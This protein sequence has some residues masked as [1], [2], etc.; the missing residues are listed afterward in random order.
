MARLEQSFYQFPALNVDVMPGAVAANLRVQ[1]KVKGI[2][3][4]GPD[5]FGH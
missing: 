2:R 5:I 4:V 1:G 3:N